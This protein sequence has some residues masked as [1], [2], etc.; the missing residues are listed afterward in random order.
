MGLLD[1]WDR[2]NQRAVEKMQE[3][4]DI[5]TAPDGSRWQLAVEAN[6][7][8]WERYDPSDGGIFGL[9]LGLIIEVV[10][11]VVRLVIRRDPAPPPRFIAVV[12]SARTSEIAASRGVESPEHGKAVATAWADVIT[13]YGIAAL[14][15]DDRT[16]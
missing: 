9:V 14:D 15:A 16:G 4:V 6:D 13:R 12:R 3:A 11:F 1:R 7:T 10:V 8:R 5:V 2:R